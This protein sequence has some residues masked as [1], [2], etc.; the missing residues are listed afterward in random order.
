VIASHFDFV[1]VVVA[2]RDLVVTQAD[3]H[4]CR[5]E[6]RESDVA[7]FCDLDDGTPTGDTDPASFVR[8]VCP[9]LRIPAV[10][11]AAIPQLDVHRAG[12]QSD[13]G[14]LMKRFSRLAGGPAGEDEGR[15]VYTD[16][17]GV[18]DG[19]LRRRIENWPSARHG[20]GVDRPAELWSINRTGEGLVVLSVSW[21]GSAP[22][23]DHQIGL[24]LDIAHRLLTQR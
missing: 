2:E 18:L 12:P 14:K 19:E 8:W 11:G 21:W 3:A 10:T 17:A 6:P 23:L 9:A 16:P 7:W 1:D 24:G 15:L 5:L 20:D 22:A 4:V 13:L